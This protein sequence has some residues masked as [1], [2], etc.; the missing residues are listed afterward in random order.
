[1]GDFGEVES[2]SERRCPSTRPRTPQ[3]RALVLLSED[4][5]YRAVPKQQP[6]KG[7]ARC[8][9]DALDGLAVSHHAALQWTHRAKAVVTVCAALPS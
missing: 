4:A 2:R 6:A 5:G 1:M 9:W 3:H 7:F 8:A